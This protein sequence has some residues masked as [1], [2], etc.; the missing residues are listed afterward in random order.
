[1]VGGK[2][3]DKAATYTLATNDYM[4]GGGD[5]Y[6]MLKDAKP[7]LGVRDAKLMANDVMAYIAA[8][9]D[10]GAEGRGPHQAEDVMDSVLRTLIAA[11]G[12]ARPSRP[13]RARR[14]GRPRTRASG[15]C[16]GLDR[17]QRDR[18]PAQGLC[19]GAGEC[20]RAG[21]DPRRGAHQRIAV[22]YV[23]WGASTSRT[24]SC[25]WTVIDGEASAKPSPTRPARRPAP[26][27]RAQRHRPGAGLRQGADRDQCA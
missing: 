13:A 1:M 10:G 9:K 22:T 21:R 26:R 8:K 6:V 20:R 15:G 5:G 12:P 3:L 24:S 4:F 14:G 16:D 11:L 7:L 23:E 17:R 27:A 19:R 25:R 18:L 2:P